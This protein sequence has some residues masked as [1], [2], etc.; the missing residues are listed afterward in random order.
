MKTLQK[1]TLLENTY[2]ILEEI[3]SGGGG[4]VYKARHLRLKTDVVVKNIRDD[5][6]GKVKSRQ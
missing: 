6:L 1:G 2:E 4:V 3:G 5:V